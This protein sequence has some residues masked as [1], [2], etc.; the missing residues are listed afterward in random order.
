MCVIFYILDNNI[1]ILI[2]LIYKNRLSLWFQTIEVRC[3]V[4]VINLSKQP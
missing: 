3:V 4:I 1:G 2:I